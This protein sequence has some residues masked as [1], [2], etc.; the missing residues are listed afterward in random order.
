MLLSVLLESLFVAVSFSLNVH[1]RSGATFGCRKIPGDEG[2]PSIEEWQTLNASVSGRLMKTTPAGHVCHDPTYDAAACEALNQT[3]IYPWGHFDDPS[4]FMAAYQQNAS[5]NP[6]TPQ[7]SPCL[8]GNY[9]DYAIE[10]HNAT[11]VIAGMKFAQANNIRLVIKNTGH[12][13][14]GKSTGKGA[15]S[16]WMHN[17]KVIEAV[18]YTSSS[19]TGPAFKMGAGVQA[20][21]AYTA[22]HMAGLTVLG[23]QC[24]TVGVVG[25]YTQGGGHSLLSGKHGMGADQ[26]LEW[27]VV[28][29]DG[30]IVT[31]SPTENT[32]LYWALSG[33][34]GGTYGVVLSLISRAHPDSIIGGLTFAFSSPSGNV[35]DDALWNA[36]SFFHRNALPGILDAGAH[37]QWAV[38]GPVFFIGETTIPG[39][40]EDDMRSVMMPF[41]DY[42]TGQGIAYQLN[43][44]SYPNFY[45]HANHYIGPF[46][47][48]TFYSAQLQGGAMISRETAISNA[49][50]LELI[51][52]L[53]H[54]STTTNFTV[55]SYGFDGSVKDPSTPSNAVHSGWRDLLSYF[56]ISQQWNYNVPFAVMDE[57]E[58]QLT[59]DIMPPLQELASGAYMNE[60]DF[61]NPKWKEEFYGSNWERLSG[62][63]KKWDPEGLLY[64]TTAVGSEEWIQDK[65]GRLC[66]A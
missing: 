39:A 2:W 56:V 43:V 37:I 60:A 33:G 65:A 34:G 53:R 64:A 52:R 14:L 23:G 27:E 36:V 48:G 55:I 6:F 32:D 21:E 51:K 4:G 12:D 66:R 46:P 44:T 5:C 38:A 18:N 19:Y 28:T 1:D 50:S 7:S 59:E 8:Q 13:Y 54:I 61:R 9:V 42:L 3:W 20:F 30:K 62:L 35:D 24:I 49:T 41:T 47:Y 57:Q 63:K 22:A 31:A 45:E 29:T 40:T 17:L 10:V 11:D 25:G 15:L 26:A 58:R 16:L